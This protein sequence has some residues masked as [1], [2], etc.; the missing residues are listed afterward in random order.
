MKFKILLILL[1]LCSCVSPKTSSIKDSYSASGLAYIYELNDFERKIIS[2]KFDE[3]KRIVSHH[4]LRSGSK[5]KIINPKN[6]K[7]IYVK[8]TKKTKYPI[9][10]K[11]L[12]TKNISEELDLDKDFPYVEIQEIKKNKSF[13]VQKAITFNEEKKVHGKSPVTKIVINNISKN[14]SKKT[15]KKNNYVI[16]IAQ[17]Y[18]LDSAKILKANLLKNS[19]NLNQKLLKIIKKNENNYELFMGPYITIKTLKNDYIVLNE[20]GFEEID[21]KIN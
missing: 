10:Y 18:S 16:I 15:M 3:N 5:I 11:I 20:L 17:F 9:L 6:K 1:F 8:T 7:S 12:I 19:T 21:I 2:N 13:V 14:K 4:T